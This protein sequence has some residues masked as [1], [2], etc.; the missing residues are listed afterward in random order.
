MEHPEKY[1][2]LTIRVSGYAVHFV[3]LS[4]EQQEEYKKEIRQKYGSKA[5]DEKG[6]RVA[7]LPK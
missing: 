1:P 6:P 5:L 4:R 7:R 3:K 2:D